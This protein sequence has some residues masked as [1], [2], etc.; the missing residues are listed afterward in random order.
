[1]LLTGNVL[2]N[3]LILKIAALILIDRGKL[4]VDTP[5]YEYFPELRNPIIFDSTTVTKDSSFRPPE[6][7]IL[8]KHLLNQSSG[9]FYPGINE[10]TKLGVSMVDVYAEKQTHLATD[11]V[12]DFLKR[13]IVG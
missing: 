3:D 11:P 10:R 8:V 5:V 12:S 13:I 9:M 2:N 4:S 1:V 7:P 6:N